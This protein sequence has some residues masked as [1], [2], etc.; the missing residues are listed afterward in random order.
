M[1]IAV[2]DIGTNSMRLLIATV[3]G[4]SIIE[5]KKWLFP[6]RMGEG[7]APANM[8]RPHVLERNVEALSQASAL[9]REY[10]AE[11][12][13][14]FGTSAL[15][16]AKN[17]RDFVKKA[18]EETGI[19]VHIITGEMESKLAYLGIMRSMDLKNVFILDVGGG[20]TEWVFVEEGILC[21]KGSI[22][23]GAV[24]LKERYL[25]Q[26][27]PTQEEKKALE[28]LVKTQFA[29]AWEHIKTEGLV[30]VA[31]GGTATTLSAIQQKMETYEPEKIQNSRLSRENLD[32]IFQMLEAKSL[33]DRKKVIGLQASRADVILPGMM[34]LMGAM[35]VARQKMLYI[36]D[37]DNLEGAVYE[38]FLGQ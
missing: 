29:R 38:F 20:S 32:E 19:T 14:A 2:I 25:Y 31:I 8:L 16:D 28:S 26:D 4:N 15:R 22:D 21:A 37:S 33:D 12:I 5:K 3:E 1:K 11:E 18:Q 27:P 13:Y 6:T 9:C 23:L 35:E 30:M 10:G 36:S 24:R 7:L 34:I 17:A